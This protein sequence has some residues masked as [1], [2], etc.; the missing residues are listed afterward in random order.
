MTGH[1]LKYTFA[2][3]IVSV[4]T[5]TSSMNDEPYNYQGEEVQPTNPETPGVAEVEKK[6]KEAEAK[7]ANH[8][9]D[10]KQTE[11]KHDTRAVQKDEKVKEP[12]VTKS[13]T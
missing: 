12:A 2:T 1:I 10:M 9:T 6:L 7:T 3:L 5:I 8:V 13:G 11:E 4:E